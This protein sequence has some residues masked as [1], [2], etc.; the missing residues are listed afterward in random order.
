MHKLILATVCFIG[1]FKRHVWQSNKLHQISI[2]RLNFTHFLSLIYNSYA[3]LIHLNTS[4]IIKH[5]LKVKTLSPI[6]TS[7]R[8]WFIMWYNNITEQNL[9]MINWLDD[10]VSALSVYFLQTQLR[11]AEWMWSGLIVSETLR[12]DPQTLLIYEFRQTKP[13]IHWVWIQSQQT[14]IWSR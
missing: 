11:A 1:R 7:Y 10:T 6:Y 14:V 12:C 13:I 9:C 8:Y 3:T 5:L 4:V 2:K